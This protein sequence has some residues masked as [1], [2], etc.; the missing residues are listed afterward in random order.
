M[1]SFDT[2]LSINLLA[3][4][5]CHGT[6][7][8]TC[9]RRKRSCDKRLPSCQAC[10]SRGLYCEGY[11]LRWAGQASADPSRLR[12]Q[13]PKLPKIRS[14]VQP[15]SELTDDDGLD[16]QAAI[17]L[18]DDSTRGYDIGP[19]DFPDGLGHLVNYDARQ[20]G[21]TFFQARTPE[22]NP[23]F[24]DIIQIARDVAP[25]RFALA[26]SASFHLSS[27]A[28]APHLV[29]QSFQL[30]GKATRLLRERLQVNR[31]QD[32]AGSLAAML[33][34]AQLDV[35]MSLLTKYSTN[36]NADVYWTLYRI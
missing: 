24:T 18:L 25:I 31:P 9:R 8:I 26:S 17:A 14:F 16:S 10:G 28:H 3:T 23:Y 22:E 5:Q 27:T 21:P 30:R 29:V 33:V 13:K 19:E 11:V 1:A 35:G 15:G 2:S 34:L 32:K 36:L 12:R 6:A 4:N 20:L 7:C